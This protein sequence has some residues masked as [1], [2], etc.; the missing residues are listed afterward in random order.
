MLSLQDVA[1]VSPNPFSAWINFEVYRHEI[2]TP[3]SAG[4]DFRR[5]ILTSID[6]RIWRLKSKAWTERVKSL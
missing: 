5:Q 2:L 3:F 4:I 1:D 6:V